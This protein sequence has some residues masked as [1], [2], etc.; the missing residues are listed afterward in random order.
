MKK[1]DHTWDDATLDAYL[2]EPRK[3]VPGTK[4]IF[5]GLKDKKDRG[6]LIAY[7]DTLK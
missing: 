5:A 7:L 4:M 1:F 3:L 2:V 6:D